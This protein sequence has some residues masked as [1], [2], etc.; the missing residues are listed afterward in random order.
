MCWPSALLAVGHKNYRSSETEK[1]KKSSIFKNAC[2]PWKVTE[3]L[4]QEMNYLIPT[5]ETTAA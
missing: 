4:K 5:L 1:T 2:H 3:R